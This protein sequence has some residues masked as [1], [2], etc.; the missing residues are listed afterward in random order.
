MHKLLWL[1]K[2]GTILAPS[3]HGGQHIL[4]W[5]DTPFLNKDLLRGSVGH[6]NVYSSTKLIPQVFSWVEV[7]TDIK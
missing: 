1:Q 6:S 3:P 7:W 4:L 5:D 2:L